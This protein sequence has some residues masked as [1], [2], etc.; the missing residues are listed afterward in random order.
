MNA[1]WNFVIVQPK[2]VF[3]HDGIVHGGS[4]PR[5]RFRLL[6]KRI[7][8]KAGKLAIAQVIEECPVDGMGFA[9]GIPIV[10]GTEGVYKQNLIL[11]GYLTHAFDV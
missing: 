9:V 7:G 3:V 11:L 5:C 2:V 4:K 8:K 10:R 1:V 6:E